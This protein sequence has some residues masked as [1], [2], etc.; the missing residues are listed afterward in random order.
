MLE[1]WRYAAIDPVDLC[2]GDPLLSQFGEHVIENR[3]FVVCLRE[4]S[5][6]FSVDFDGDRMP[7]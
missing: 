2:I 5:T 7:I 3:V 4:E 6:V 1:P